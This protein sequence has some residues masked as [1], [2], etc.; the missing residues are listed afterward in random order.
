MYK[1][2]NYY[3]PEGGV[4]EYGL[5][6]PVLDVKIHYRSRPI[7]AF[8]GQDNNRG[9]MQLGRIELELSHKTLSYKEIEKDEKDE[10]S[11]ILSELT[12][13]IDSTLDS[14]NKNDLLSIIEESVAEEFEPDKKPKNV[15]RYY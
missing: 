2:S 1:K 8:Q 14:I 6:Y 12:S 10:N 7:L 13:S 5:Y 15:Y 9:A 11:K 4:R 3:G